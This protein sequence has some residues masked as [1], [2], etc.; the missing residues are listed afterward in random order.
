MYTFETMLREKGCMAVCGIDEAGCGPLAGPVYAAAV[1]LDPRDPIEGVDDSKKL[2][3]KKREALY[4]QIT[5]RARAW[6]VASASAEE[7]DQINILQARL[8]AMRRAVE[9]LNTVPDYALVDGNRDPA[10]PDIPTLLIVGG[11][12]KSASIGAA[13]I[14]AKVT[15]DRRMLE[16]DA[17]YPQYQFARHKGYPTKLH[18]EKLLEYGPCPE[19]RQSFLKKIWERNGR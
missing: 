6:A 10:I 13:S 8:L 7:I 15:R 1:I 3:E 14:L 12:G 11:D 5:R 16:L 9:R 17:Q 18:V 2:S 4:D 19:H